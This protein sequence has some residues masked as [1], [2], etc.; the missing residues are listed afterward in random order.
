MG[1]LGL[2]SCG[3]RENRRKQIR[4]GCPESDQSEHQGV[5]LTHSCP[6]PPQRSVDALVGFSSIGL[7]F[8]QRADALIVI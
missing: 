6:R 7:H 5:S 3:A 8:Q 4:Q 1:G 2:H